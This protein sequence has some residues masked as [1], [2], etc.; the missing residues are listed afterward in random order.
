[1]KNKPIKQQMFIASFLGSLSIVLG[2]FSAHGLEG[3]V[4]SGILEPHYIQVFEKAVKYQIYHSIVLLIL[5]LFNLSHKNILFLNSFRI[6]LTGIILFSGSLYWIAL[7]QIIHI[8]FPHFLFWITPLGGLFM[9][10]GWV[11]IFIE[12]KKIIDTI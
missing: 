6:M 1:M 5:A 11:Y 7:Q 10:V 2:A 12:S 3:L 9:I 8:P 4:K